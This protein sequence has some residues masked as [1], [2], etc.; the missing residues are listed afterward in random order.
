MAESVYALIP[1]A[2][3]A[4]AAAA[5]YR[6]KF[7]SSHGTAPTASTFGFA[8][9]SLVLGNVAG[10]TDMATVHPAKKPFGTFGVVVADT[11]KPDTF[12]RKGHS[13]SAAAA[14]S[15]TSPIRI[16]RHSDSAKK[17]AI[18]TLADKPVM[19]L[20]TDKNFVVAN[21]VENIL[22][23]SKKQGPQQKR[24]VEREDY[25]KV[26]DYINTIKSELASQYNLIDQHKASKAAE[27]ER[28]HQLSAQEVHEL[29]SGLQ[30]RWDH[31]NKEFQTMGFS[32][33]TFTQKKRQEHVE[34]ELRCIEQALQKIRK[35]NI[36]VYDDKK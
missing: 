1:E 5:R 15:R 35:S 22:A 10:E 30:Q 23:V 25:G 8:G 16:D 27:A 11:V 19:G 12:L 36:F 7:A 34:L 31:L 14:A 33:E 17:P 32:V 26:P 29:R 24:A 3:V 9:T 6:S 21:A 20:K 4:P 2:K 18:P 28:F 13:A